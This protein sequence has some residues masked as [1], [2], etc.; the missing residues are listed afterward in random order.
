M[1]RKSVSVALPIAYMPFSVAVLVQMAI[2]NHG[3]VET[4]LIEKVM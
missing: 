4:D 3:V 2:T 1:K